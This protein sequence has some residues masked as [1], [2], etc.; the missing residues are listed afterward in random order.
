MHSWESLRC[1][2]AGSLLNHEKAQLGD[3]LLREA[4]PS[5]PGHL[6]TTVDSPEAP[7]MSPPP[8]GRHLRR[9]SSKSEKFPRP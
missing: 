8:R 4:Q 9:V 7:A 6:E 1:V 3:H 5:S 2:F